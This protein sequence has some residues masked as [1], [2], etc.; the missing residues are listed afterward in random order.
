MEP[1][2]FRADLAEGPADCVPLWRHA[3][4]GVRLR[5][6]YWPVTGARG[7]VLLFPGRTEHIEKY[8]RMAGDLAGAG[9]ATVT[10]DWRGQGFSERLAGDPSLGHVGTFRDYQLDVAEVVAAAHLAGLPEPWHLLAHS[11]GGCIGFRS[12]VEGLPVA[13]A[14]FTAPMWGIHLPV[15]MRPL[16]FLL[17]PLWRL[18]RR[19]EAYAPGT[20]AESYLAQAL[21]E[22]N[23]LTTDEESFSFMTRHALAEPAFALGGPSVHWVGLAAVECR[24]F[25]RMPKPAQPVLTFLGSDEEVVSPGAIRRLHAAWPSAQLREV[26][27]AKHELMMEAP[28]LREPFLEETLSFFAAA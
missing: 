3:A 27:G 1:V 19:H 13:R 20:T 23:A 16:P 14:V 10:L 28:A 7:T 24:R 6:A 4:D 8:G 26:V 5:L 15:R 18:A 11:M 22:E 21:F 12:L 2:P 9:Y 25:L 17:P